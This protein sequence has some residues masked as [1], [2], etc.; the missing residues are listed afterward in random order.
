ML[1]IAVASEGD[2]VTEHFGHCESFTIF[3][4][5]DGVVVNEEKIANPGHKPGFLP[6]FLADQGVKVMIS[7]CMGGGAVDV[8]NSRNVEVITGAEGLAAEVVEKYLKGEIS[9]NG[10]VCHKH[11]HSHECGKHK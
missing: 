10:A 6:N 9:S 1:K 7:G 4:S 11:E 5:E 2:L 3:T 8:F